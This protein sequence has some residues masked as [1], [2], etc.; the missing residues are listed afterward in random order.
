[1]I[2]RCYGH[3]NIRAKHKNSIEITKDKEIS[4]AADCVLGVDASYSEHDLQ[5]FSG[6]YKVKVELECGGVR[7]TIYGITPETIIGK[8]FILRKSN[9]IDEKTFM[10][11]CDKSAL[12]INQSL[13]EKL[14]KG[15][16]MFVKIEILEKYK[17]DEI[18]SL[19][20]LDN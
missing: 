4:E 17:E 13:V 2:F 12:E 15:K 3:N 10:I 1:M 7:E 18:T 6:E 14:K 11:R 5:K 16:K 19:A 8:G 9:F 20:Y